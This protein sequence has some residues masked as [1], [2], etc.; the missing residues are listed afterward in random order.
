MWK[1]QYGIKNANAHDMT[2]KTRAILQTTTCRGKYE[3][4]VEIKEHLDTY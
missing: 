3:S 4:N 2:N 1:S